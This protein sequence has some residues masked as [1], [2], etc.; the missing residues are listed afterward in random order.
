M[1]IFNSPLKKPQQKP[2][3]ADLPTSREGAKSPPK[4]LNGSVAYLKAGD[5]FAKAQAAHAE[6]NREIREGT[7]AKAIVSV[8]LTVSVVVVAIQTAFSLIQ[9]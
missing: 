6:A 4:I 9:G 1:A 3:V 2:Q 8:T 7:G 5:A